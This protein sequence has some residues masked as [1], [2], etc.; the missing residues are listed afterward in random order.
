MKTLKFASLALLAV[1][2]VLGSCSKYEEGPGLSL[3]T[4]KARITGEWKVEKNVDENGE[5]SEPGQFDSNAILELT[6]DNEAFITVDGDEVGEGTW[7]FTDSKESV[8][9]DISVLGFPSE[10]ETSRILK[11]KNDEMWIADADE[12]NGGEDYGGYTVYVSVD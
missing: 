3:R 2:F 5:E 6:K 1:T 12:D 9:M 10:P 7:E 11:L 4:K 8:T